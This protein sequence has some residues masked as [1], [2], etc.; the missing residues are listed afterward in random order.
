[1]SL[2]GLATA[3]PGRAQVLGEPVLVEGRCDQKSGVR[4]GDSPT[5]TFGC[6]VGIITRSDRGTV[7]FQFTDKAGED[8]RILGF[9]GTLEGKQSLGADPIQVMAVERIY[10][11]LGGVPIVADRG[12]CFL[13][14]K[15]KI[16]TSAVC[17]AV[18][19]VNGTRIEARVMVE[20]K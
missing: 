3:T 1:M 20:A 18:G 14:W 9:A 7:L 2:L 13:N 17:G 8:G 12:T 16:A 11:K 15:G 19:D 5:S 4:I 10:L 6:D